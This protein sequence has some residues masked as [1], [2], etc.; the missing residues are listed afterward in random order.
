MP[1]PAEN[2]W[3]K[4]ER[5]E[6]KGT[7][8]PKK[9]LDKKFY[10]SDGSEKLNGRAEES[11][12][13][14]PDSSSSSSSSSEESEEEPK[15][16]PAVVKPRQ[17]KKPQ[18]TKPLPLPAASESSSSSDSDSDEDVKKPAKKATKKPGA[19]PATKP[20]CS[21]HSSHLIMLCQFGHQQDKTR[22]G[23]KT[24]WKLKPA[25]LRHLK[26]MG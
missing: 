5:E 10:E 16:E 19:T 23:R 9:K 25:M 26:L 11:E 7:K 8:A 13:S 12:D 15:V 24:F 18:K 22:L 2:P 1:K 17:Q 3:R 14:S 6:R 20:R 21:S 4:E